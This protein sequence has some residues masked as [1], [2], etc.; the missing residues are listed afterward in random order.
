MNF[1]DIDINSQVA[2]EFSFPYFLPIVM[3]SFFILEYLWFYFTMRYGYTK[4]A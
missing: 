1:N 3:N 2:E 4:V